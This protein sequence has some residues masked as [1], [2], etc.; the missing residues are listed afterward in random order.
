MGE[1]TGAYHYASE[2]NVDLSCSRILRDINDLQTLKDCFDVH[3][4]FDE[5]EPRLKSLSSGLIGDGAIN[6]D[7]AEE[8]GR[9]IQETLNGVKMEKASIKRKDKVQNFEDLMPATKIDDKVVH[10]DATILFSRLT[11]LANLKKNIVDNFSYE[12]TPEPTSLFKHGLI[13][14][15]NK[16]TLL[17]RKKLL[18]Q[19]SSMSVLLMVGH[20]FTRSSCQKQL[21]LKYLIALKTT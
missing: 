14:K 6:C 20:Y 7:E 17:R 3:D 15:P 2:Q 8:I 16:A 5:D 12:L 4:P 19:S 9:K 13:R 10:I 11:A 1:L 18:Y 21:M